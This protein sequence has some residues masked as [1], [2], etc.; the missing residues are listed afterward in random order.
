MMQELKHDLW[1]LKTIAKYQI[2]QDNIPITIW[3]I[4]CF[5]PNSNKWS[6]Q[7]SP[8]NIKSKNEEH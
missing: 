8:L 5:L 4:F 3:S 1:E 6:D 2:I 7:L